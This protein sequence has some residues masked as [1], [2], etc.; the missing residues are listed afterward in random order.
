MYEVVWGG[1]QPQ[2]WSCGIISTP[3]VNLNP[4]IWGQLGQCNGIRV[5]PYAN[6][7]AYQC[8]KHFAYD[9]Y[10][11]MKWSEVDV[12]F[13]HD[14]IAVFPLLKWTWQIPKLKKT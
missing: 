1:Y 11:C 2:P 12:S 10:E 9:Q 3:Q 4:Q 6:E 8:L 13:N 14:V 5:Q 7:T